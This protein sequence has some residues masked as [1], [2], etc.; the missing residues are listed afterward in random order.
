MI[1]TL[2]ELCLMFL[3]FLLLIVPPNLLTLSQYLSTFQW[4]KEAFHGHLIYPLTRG[5]LQLLNLPRK[6]IIIDLEYNPL[7]PSTIFLCLWNLNEVKSKS[8]VLQ[9]ELW[10]QLTVQQTHVIYMSDLLFIRIKDRID[11]VN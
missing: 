8:K 6:V 9:L 7:Q 10:D 11:R 1:E 3:I 4:W 5:K 2:T